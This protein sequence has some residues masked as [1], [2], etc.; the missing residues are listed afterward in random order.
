MG[1]VAAFTS[2]STTGWMAD[3]KSFSTTGWMADFKSF[4]TTGCTVDFKSF[5]DSGC[6][7]AG[8]SAQVI[9]S[10]KSIGIPIVIDCPSGP[11]TG[12]DSKLSKKSR[13]IG[14]TIGGGDK[15]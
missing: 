2:F 1:W 15:T 13:S 10:L 5:S 9:K 6:T 12:S 11:A 7:V 3:F 4:S 14:V 8:V